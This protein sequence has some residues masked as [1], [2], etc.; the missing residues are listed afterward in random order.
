M[1]RDLLDGETFVSN[2]NGITFIS[3]RV[4][5]HRSR[6]STE[7]VQTLS[8][9]KVQHGAV[10]RTHQIWLVILAVTAMVVAGMIALAG[11]DAGPVVVLVGAA[12]GCLL[13]YFMTRSLELQVGAG[14]GLI[15]VR[16]NAGKVAAEAATAFLQQIDW[17]VAQRENGA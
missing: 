4:L 16:V 10:V 8:L 15:R 14:A 5:F 17:A 12:G 9:A 1:K 7:S 13:A 3:Q 11:G 6:G 2:W